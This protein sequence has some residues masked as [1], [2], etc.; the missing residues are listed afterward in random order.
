MDEN[1]QQERMFILESLKDFKAKAE[2]HEE[3]LTRLRIENDE[4]KKDLD[5]AHSKIRAQEE[6]NEKLTRRL[7][8]LEIRAGYI[9]AASGAIIGF[10]WELARRFFGK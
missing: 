4:Q 6:Q 9:A 10:A 1:Y 7:T 5:A 2:A 3:K 8:T